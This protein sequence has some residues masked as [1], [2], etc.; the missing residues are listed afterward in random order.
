MSHFSNVEQGW[1]PRILQMFQIQQNSDLLPKNCKNKS[2]VTHSDHRKR[3]KWPLS[4]QRIHSLSHQHVRQSEKVCVTLLA[5][6]CMFS[7]VFHVLLCVLN[8][9]NTEYSVSIFVLHIYL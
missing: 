7:C 4:T 9:K 6:C 2:P 3:E 8:V 1:G 5:L